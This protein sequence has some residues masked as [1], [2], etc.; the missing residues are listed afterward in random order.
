MGNSPDPPP[1]TNNPA[2]VIPA[3]QAANTQAAAESQAG[4]MVNQN[5]PWGSLNYSQTGTGP[6]GIPIYTSTMNLNPQLE[7]ILNSLQSGIGNQLTTGGYNQPGNNPGEI[8]GDATKGNTQA[9]VNDYTKFF[10]PQ[11]TT[12]T[13]QLD[14]QLRNQGLS[15]SQSSDPN[16]PST[17]GP[18][19]R[20]MNQLQTTQNQALSGFITQME[21]QA[22]AQATSNYYAPL[23]TASGL[24]SL[25]TPSNTN[26]LINPPQT[27]VQAPDVTGAYNSY[28]N[29]LDQQYAQKVQANS[30]MM[31]GLM[32]IPTAVLGGWAKGGGLGSL[33]GGLGG[34]AD[35]GGAAAAGMG[36]AAGMASLLADLG[37]L[38]MV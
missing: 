18:Y 10:N 37:P 1:V 15:P 31:S 17:W 23:T 21:P 3:Q 11:W 27:Q 32:G 29:A 34:A 12:Q 33:F 2:T 25:I 8:I 4:S 26:A 7:A 24:M 36:D 22:Y 13:Q 14:T 6:G 9:L 35:A 16:N 5:N 30:S 19:E 28:Q 38:A 20:A